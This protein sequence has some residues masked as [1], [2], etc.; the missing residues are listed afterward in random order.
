[1]G[2][3]SSKDKALKKWVV[4]SESTIIYVTRRKICRTVWSVNSRRDV[5][6]GSWKSPSL[7]N[8]S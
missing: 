7:V 8:Y 2:S 4:F 1:M 3:D 5:I 6:Q